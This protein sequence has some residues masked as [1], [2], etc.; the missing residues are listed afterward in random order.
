MTIRELYRITFEFLPKKSHGI[1]M[2]VADIEKGYFV[3][4]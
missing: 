4:E 2:E 3:H 1:K